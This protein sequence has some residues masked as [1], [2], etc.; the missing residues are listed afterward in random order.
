MAAVT[1]VVQTP[2]GQ[3]PVF[4]RFEKQEPSWVWPLYLQPSISLCRRSGRF[5]EPFL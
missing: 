2:Q 4:S 1:A 5:Y 3:R